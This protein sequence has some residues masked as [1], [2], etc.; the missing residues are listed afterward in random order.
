MAVAFLCCQHLPAPML[1]GPD[2][3]AEK[4][5]NRPGTDHPGHQLGGPAVVAV[6][7]ICGWYEDAADITGE[8]EHLNVR[9]RSL[10][11]RLIELIQAP[12]R[13]GKRHNIG[14]GDSQGSEGASQLLLAE[15]RELSL[16]GKVTGMGRL[17]I[18]YRQH[19]NGDTE[20]SG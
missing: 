6:A 18:G 17:A 13:Q 4:M 7:V 12:V 19:G 5:F 16:P 1:R 2:L 14:F 15:R 10:A 8:K 9:L 11:G 3:V 20:R